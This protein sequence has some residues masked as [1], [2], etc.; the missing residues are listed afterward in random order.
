[1]KKQKNFQLATIA[2]LVFAVLFMAIGF[3][4][5]S[6]TVKLNG[7]IANISKN[8]WSA[9]FSTDESD[10]QLETGSVEADSHSFDETKVDFAASLSK[11][12]DHHTFKMKVVNDG[13]FQ[14]ALKS[15]IL[16]GLTAEQEKY[17]TYTVT[18]ADDVY[19]MSTDNLNIAL[20][21][22]GSEEVIVDVQYVQPADSIIPPADEVTV[23]LSA[24]LNYSQAN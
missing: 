24:Q 14:A 21:V 17:V 20:P 2:V 5:Y 13:T 18:Y 12:G 15:I 8:K 9:H 19:D 3:A 16:S 7:G 10:Y 6:Q 4:T 22:G 11:P 1:M 23:N